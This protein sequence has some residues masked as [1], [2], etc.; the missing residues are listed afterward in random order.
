ME[1]RTLEDVISDKELE[2]FKKYKKQNEQFLNNNLISSFLEK[3]ENYILL[4]KAI[5]SPSK[6]NKEKLD[7]AFKRYYFNIRFTSYISTALYYNAI[8][9]DKKHRKNQNRYPLTVDKPI[10][11]EDEGTFK[12]MICDPNAEYNVEDISKGNSIVDYLEDPLLYKAVESLTEKQRQILDFAY[13]NGL[14]DTD[15][16]LV[17]N[18][19]QQ[20]VSKTRKKALQNI[21]DFLQR[22][23]GLL[24]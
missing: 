16:G 7:M 4:K 23:G 11:D 1:A 15:I 9:F 24:K 8:N 20:S 5:C 6:E 3:R 22:K 19:S 17:L 14:S 12:D 21:Y 18:K 2:E 10:S 13:V